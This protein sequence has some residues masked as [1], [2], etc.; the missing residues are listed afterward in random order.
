MAVGKVV[1]LVALTV[2]WLVAGKVVTTVFSL[3][4]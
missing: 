3:A 4:E 2:D 1:R